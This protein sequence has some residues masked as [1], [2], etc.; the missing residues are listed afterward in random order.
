MTARSLQVTF[1]RT[2]DRRYR[3]SVE[4]S[5]VTPS[6]MDPAPG[7]DP[8]LPHDMAHFIVENELGI[9]GGVFG[10][11]AAGGTAGT[12][13]PL[14]DD[15]RRRIRR[16]GKR[17]ATSNKK[18]AA[19]SEQ[20]IFIAFQVWQNKAEVGS[21]KGVA[22]KD[23]TRVVREF[24]AASAIWSKLDVGESMTLV[25]RAGARHPARRSRR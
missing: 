8:R 7:Y 1:T 17:I 25:W 18:D 11:V 3:V 19:L 15:K 9:K 2:G 22:A 13:I 5:G 24:E 12:F 16:R 14:D 21:F 4:G 6:Y 10:Q 23:I 20:L